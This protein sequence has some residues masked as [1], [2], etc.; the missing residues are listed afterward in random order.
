LIQLCVGVLMRQSGSILISVP[1]VVCGGG[2]VKDV[3]H[4]LGTCGHV[5]LYAV[6]ESAKFVGCAPYPLYTIWAKDG[7]RGG[8][9]HVSSEFVDYC[10][11]V[12]CWRGVGVGVGVDGSEVIHL[13]LCGASCVF[14]DGG[15]CGVST[16]GLLLCND[17]GLVPGWCGPVCLPGTECSCV[18]G[19]WCRY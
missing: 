17:G 12:F 13:L 10:I 5:W 6:Y 16:V 2:C 9:H 1:W 8:L 19:V 14:C 18:M 7:P 11:G 4:F 3:A 15:R